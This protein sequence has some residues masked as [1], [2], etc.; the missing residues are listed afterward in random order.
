MRCSRGKTLHM[1]QGY[2]SRL[3]TVVLRVVRLNLW[4]RCDDWGSAL[5]SAFVSLG[6]AVVT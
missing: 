5:R 3:E 2:A 6:A 4:L 1:T